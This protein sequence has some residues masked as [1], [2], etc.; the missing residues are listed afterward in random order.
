MSKQRNRDK[1]TDIAKGVG[2][3][4]VV[5]LHSGL[6]FLTGVDMPLFFLISGFFAPSLVKY[7]FWGGVEKKTLTLL[8]PTL[9]YLIFFGILSYLAPLLPKSGIPQHSFWHFLTPEQLIIN[10]L[11]YQPQ[12]YFAIT[13]WFVSALWMGMLLWLVLRYLIEPKLEN[14]AFSCFLVFM[15][16]GVYFSSI[17]GPSLDQ[18]IFIGCLGRAIYAF[19]FISFGFVLS[20]YK[21]SLLYGNLRLIV[22]V[23]GCIAIYWKIRYWNGL[24]IADVRTMSFDNFYKTRSIFVSFCGI[25]FIFA[26]SIIIARF[27]LLA[28]ITDYLG[29]KSFHI[30]ALHPL[31]IFLFSW[32]MRLCGIEVTPGNCS[33]IFKIGFLL[34]GLLFSLL[35]IKTW[36]ITVALR[37]KYAEEKNNSVNPNSLLFSKVSE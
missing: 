22:F 16:V 33:I 21:Q 7:S 35:C 26:V 25:A 30:M 24:P 28:R 10:P 13:L 32:I 15:L 4:L 1:I 37:N 17:N 6:A 27:E 2:I 14:K 9:K 3:F 29:A 20:S 23:L 34:S 8:L 31:G 11:F 12:Q 5:C 36:D 19:V 18:N